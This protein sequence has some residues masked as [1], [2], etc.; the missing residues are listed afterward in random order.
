MLGPPEVVKLGQVD[1][2]TKDEHTRPMIRP[3]SFHQSWPKPPAAPAE[4][5]P[6]GADPGAG[7]DLESLAKAVELIYQAIDEAAEVDGIFMVVHEMLESQRMM[8][9]AMMRIVASEPGRLNEQWHDRVCAFRSEAQR[10]TIACRDDFNA[11]QRLR[12]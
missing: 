5:L 6:I 7:S 2:T 9:D 3:M 12:E 1:Q 8:I 4:P 11:R 10:Q